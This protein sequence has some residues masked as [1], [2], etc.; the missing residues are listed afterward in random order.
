MDTKTRALFDV[1][2]SVE[3]RCGYDLWRIQG[4]C[5]GHMIYISSPIAFSIAESWIQTRNTRY[6]IMDIHQNPDEFWKQVSHDV[7]AGGFQ[8]C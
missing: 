2:Y 4:I 8:T 1:K 7:E 6:Y 3:M 5:E